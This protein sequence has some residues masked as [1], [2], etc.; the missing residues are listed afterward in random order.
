MRV[1]Q[2]FILRLLV[3]PTEPETLRG[4]LQPLPE[5]APHPF[6]DEQKMLRVLRWMM[7]PALVQEGEAPQKES[8]DEGKG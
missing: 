7:R 3:D 2:T 4:T 8:T 6:T 1:V 5:G